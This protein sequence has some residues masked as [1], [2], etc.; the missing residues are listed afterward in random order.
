MAKLKRIVA[1]FASMGVREKR[2]RPRLLCGPSS[3]WLKLGLGRFSQFYYL[4]CRQLPRGVTDAGL[5]LPC[6]PPP[7][8]DKPIKTAGNCT[9]RT[10]AIFIHD[11]HTYTVYPPKEIMSKIIIITFF[12]CVF[13]CRPSRHSCCHFVRCHPPWFPFHHIGIA[14]WIQIQSAPVDFECLD[15]SRV[16]FVQTRIMHWIINE[17]LSLRFTL[18]WN[19]VWG[20]TH[21]YRLSVYSNGT[22]S[23]R[24]KY[25]NII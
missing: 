22:R 13:G 5:P 1:L 24:D 10:P 17:I 21:T 6:L 12:S 7:K 16:L 2:A 3:E 8:V 9:T 23:L 20:Q 11:E 14:S 15:E 4:A 19:L 18:K 25:G